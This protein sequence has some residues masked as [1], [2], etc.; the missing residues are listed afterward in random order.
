[1]M[2]LKGIYLFV[3]F[4]LVACS[5][6][7][8]VTGQGSDDVLPLSYASPEYQSLF[9]NAQLEKSRGNMTKAAQLFQDCMIM[10][11]TLMA[12]H[13]ENA[14]LQLE[15]F[16]NPSQAIQQLKTC[17]ESDAKNPWYHKVFADALCF[18]LAPTQYCLFYDNFSDKKE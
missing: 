16:N 5:G 10:E 7:K 17:I 3:L 11:P 18:R 8:Q 9:F 15:Y 1:M 13:Y 12:A 14:R 2:K 6:G 4:A